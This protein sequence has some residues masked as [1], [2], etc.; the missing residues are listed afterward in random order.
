MLDAD[1]RIGDFHLDYQYWLEEKPELSKF[2]QN[3][4]SE[5]ENE[6]PTIKVPCLMLFP[7]RFYTASGNSLDVQI[8]KDHI[9]YW[10]AILGRALKLDWVQTICAHAQSVELNKNE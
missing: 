1:I 7:D 10:A 2:N 8:E 5:N 6:K 9:E 4:N 3:Q